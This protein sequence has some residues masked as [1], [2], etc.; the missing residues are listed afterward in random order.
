MLLAG[1]DGAMTYTI[2]SRA[3]SGSI[4]TVNFSFAAGVIPARRMLALAT[5]IVL[6]P[7]VRAAV[8]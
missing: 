2:S 5:D 8:R 6:A 1:V 7:E 3:V 4:T